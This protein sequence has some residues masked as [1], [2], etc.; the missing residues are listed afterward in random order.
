M[1]GRLGDYTFDNWHDLV[2]LTIWAVTFWV[3]FFVPIVR[4]RRWNLLAAA[5][6][7]L[8]GVLAFLTTVGVV[9]MLY[10]SIDLAWT[11]PIFRDVGSVINIIIIYTGLFPGGKRDPITR[12]SK[13]NPDEPDRGRRLFHHR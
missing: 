1:L 2:S 10:P 7:A 12:P 5:L 3:L 4:V 9:G 11:K 6:T 8:A 13:E